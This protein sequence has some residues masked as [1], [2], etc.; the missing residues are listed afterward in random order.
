VPSFS[1]RRL[2]HII[3]TPHQKPVFLDRNRQASAQSNDIRCSDGIRAENGVVDRQVVGL[4]S[5]D[6]PIVLAALLWP[7]VLTAATFQIVRHF[8]F[9]DLSN[10]AFDA[11]THDQGGHDFLSV[12]FLIHQCLELLSGLLTWW[13]P[14]H[15]V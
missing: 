11:Q 4:T 7:V 5:L 14:M 9:G 10:H 1:R 13:Y 8:R 3:T 6:E 15:G 12:Q 2:D